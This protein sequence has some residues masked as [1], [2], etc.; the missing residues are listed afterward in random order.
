MVWPGLIWFSMVR[1]PPSLLVSLFR[2]EGSICFIL[3]LFRLI[4]SPAN[5]IP[6]LDEATNDLA[7]AMAASRRKGNRAAGHSNRYPRRIIAYLVCS[8]TVHGEGRS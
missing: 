7:L 2:T 3:T 5:K 8:T 4:F 6:G 1:S